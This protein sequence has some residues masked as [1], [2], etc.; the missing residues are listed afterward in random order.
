MTAVGTDASKTLTEV[1]VNDVAGVKGAET[2]WA[3]VP[4]NEDSR[5]T[6]SGRKLKAKTSSTS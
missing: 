2:H 6:G 1:A 4:K 5:T 3:A